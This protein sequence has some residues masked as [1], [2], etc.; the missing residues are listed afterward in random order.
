[1]SDSRSSV[2]ADHPGGFRADDRAVSTALS[3]TLTLTVTAILIS[4][5]LVSGTQFL[6]SE[7]KRAIDSE[8]DVLGNRVA[9]DLAAADRLVQAGNDTG[10]VTVK[11]TEDMPDTVAGAPYRM[12]ITRA[13][14]GPYNVTIELF[15]TDPSVSVTV[16]VQTTTAVVNTTIVGG[17]FVIEYNESAEEL[18][19]TDD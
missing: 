15:T 14:S 19:V 11:L 18:E 8:L 16:G 13:D 17:A 6:E 7:Q 9:A 4:G 12:N 1:M 2:R 5:L 10:A 3:Y